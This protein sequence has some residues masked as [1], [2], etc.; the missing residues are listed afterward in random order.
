MGH[1]QESLGNLIDLSPE[2]MR[3]TR[4]NLT[5]AKFGSSFCCSRQDRNPRIPDQY[6]ASTMP[7]P[8]AS[9]P[10]QND[11]T[12]N[13]SVPGNQPEAPNNAEAQSSSAAGPS[14]GHN[15]SSPE[16]QSNSRK[17][18][19]G[20]DFPSSSCNSPEM[21]KSSSK[22]RRSD[23][24]LGWNN[25]PL[26]IRDE[27]DDVCTPG[28]RENLQRGPLAQVPEVHLED[29]D[30]NRRPLLPPVFNPER[31]DDHPPILI[32][33]HV[34]EAVAGIDN[35]GR[36][37][38][39][40]VKLGGFDMRNEQEQGDE[41][42]G[43]LIEY[44]GENEQ[45]HVEDH[46][47]EVMIGFNGREEQR[48]EEEHY[49]VLNEDFG[50]EAQVRKERNV[51]QGAEDDSDNGNPD[52]RNEHRSF[53]VELPHSS[54]EAGHSI[55]MSYH[56]ESLGNPIDHPQ[57]TIQRTWENPTDAESGSSSSSS[58]QDR[59]PRIPEQYDAST[60][61]RPD[62]STPPQNDPTQNDSVPG[63]QP[64]APNNAEAQSSSAAGPSVGHNFSSPE[65][66]S[67]SRKRKR[68]SDFPSSSCNSPE[69]EKS[70]SKRRRSDSK[71]GWNNNPLSIRDEHDDG[72]LLIS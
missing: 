37:R 11:P 4:E 53:F 18:K 9:T 64:E 26:S 51:L 46:V 67:N 3:R 14:V 42:F 32:P 40:L 66:Q 22:R 31:E 29:E 69:M 38:K 20:S 57:K 60:M 47:R 13:D 58:R 70:S 7:R 16:T 45:V 15:F 49:G 36:M 19:R 28:L 44:F 30:E 65:T 63:N 23:S 24:K 35:R 55:V 8:D 72:M 50:E 27:H 5:Y 68:G 10:P 17:R 1:Y 71:L 52:Y 59:N 48:L 43:V 39:M 33:E 6:N 41:H 62:A 21:E 54:S 25:N 61:P 2:A 12:Q 56:Q 34:N